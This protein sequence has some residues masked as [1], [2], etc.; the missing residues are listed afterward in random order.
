MTPIQSRMARAGLKLSTRAFAEIAEVS[1]PTLVKVEADANYNAMSD[2][3]KKIEA[4]FLRLG[5]EFIDHDA[6]RIVARPAE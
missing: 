1:Q 4:A 5:V 6:V 3:L 2:T